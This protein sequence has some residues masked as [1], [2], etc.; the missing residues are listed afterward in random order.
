M[1][2]LLANVVLLVDIAII[3]VP[4]SITA[5]RI[6]RKQL[7]L[8]GLALPILRIRR[9]LTLYGDVRPDLSIFRIDLEPLFEA[10]L[11]VRFDCV[12]RAFRFA[13]AAI[14]AFIGMNDEHVLAL[15][16]AVHRTHLDTVHVLAANAA[17][18]DDVGQLSLLA[19]VARSRAISSNPY[20]HPPSI[21]DLQ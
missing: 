2:D 19:E 17:L 20:V 1:L 8:V 7:C 10:G 11:R 9:W 5:A 12:N 16:E 6:R 3:I 21:N 13:N 14:D 4:G 18:I 15:I